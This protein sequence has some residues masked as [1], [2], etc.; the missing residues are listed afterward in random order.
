MK[1]PNAENAFVDLVKLTDYCLSPDHPRGKHKARVFQGVC[2][3]TEDNADRLQQQLLEAAEHGDAV[4]AASD[5][6]GRRFVI[7]YS[8]QGPAGA[9]RVRTAWIIRHN[10]DFPRF[11][12][13]YVM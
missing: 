8:V 7:E 10:E 3:F 11:V 6:Y 5:I 1:L 9:G 12:S 4:E 13:A 2:G